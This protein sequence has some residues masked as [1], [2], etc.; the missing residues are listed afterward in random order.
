MECSSEGLSEQSI[1]L[2]SRFL[3]FTDHARAALASLNEDGGDLL[4]ELRHLSKSFA[5]IARAAST[6]HLTRLLSPYTG[7]CN[8]IFKAVRNLSST[9]TG[10]L[11]VIQREASAEE[12]MT[13]GIPLGAEITST[14]LESIF[15]VG[16][17]LHDGA[18]L[19]RDDGIVSAANVLPL[20]KKVYRTRKMGTRHR[21]AIGLSEHTDALVFVVSEETGTPSFA[22][23]GFLYPFY[24]MD[25]E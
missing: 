1:D 23:D 5:D 7:K 10:A 18:V 16:S 13:A 14:L 21:A 3:A 11:I 25:R 24:F 20:T 15:N 9:R 8:E 4:G 2:R 17:P 6:Y 12:R 19:I 22:F